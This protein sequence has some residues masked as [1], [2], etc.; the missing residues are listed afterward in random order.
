VVS[1]RPISESNREAVEA[2]SASDAA[3][4]SVLSP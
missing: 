4:V 3:A 1:L 2:S